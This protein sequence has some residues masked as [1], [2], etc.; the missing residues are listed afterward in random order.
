M[1]VMSLA[2]SGVRKIAVRSGKK[3]KKKGPAP[4]IP[5][6]QPARLRGEGFNAGFA[7]REAMPEDVTAKPYWMAGFKTGNRVT[8]VHDPM[9]V[10]AMWIGCGDGGILLASADCIGLSRCEVMRVRNSLAD[11]ARQA[12]CQ[13]INI[14]CSH[15]HAGIDTLGYWGK[16]KVGPI[17]GDGKD[18]DFMDLFLGSIRDVCVEAYENRRE[19]KLYTGSVR[20]PEAVSD[21]RKPTVPRDV[22]GRIRFVPGDGSTETWLLNFGAHPNTLGKQ[23]TN[24]SADYP[25]YLRE[26]INETKET[27]VLF[28]AGAIASINAG[29]YGSGDRFERTV[30]QGETLAK[31]ALSI[32]ND[33]ELAPEITVLCQPYYAPIDNGVLALMGLI[34]VINAEKY[35]CERGDLGVALQSELTYIR[36]GKQ[37]ILLLPGEMKPELAFGGYAPA[38]TS[39]TARGPEIN[40]PTLCEIAG[41]ENLLVFGVTNDMT[42][43]ILAPNDFVLHETEPY[44]GQC[45]DRNGTNHYHETNSLGCLTAETIADTFKKMMDAVKVK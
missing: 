15:T 45:K 43:Y 11:F 30:L 12:N 14:S 10:S 1:S 28:T 24:V 22:L 27:N 39:A 18:A 44:L 40:P 3:L 21:G 32:D 8:G 33:E 37:R 13:S 23:N 20:V 31:A 29:G 36:L 35:P 5:E 38:E 25:Y 4:A 16:A 41:D 34:K 2:A 7:R 26:K 9:T 6:A 42:G 19:G 17:P